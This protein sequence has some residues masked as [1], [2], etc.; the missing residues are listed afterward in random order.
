MFVRRKIKLGL[1]GME[2][3]D[4]NTVC[5]VPICTIVA[6]IEM[7]HPYKSESRPIRKAPLTALNYTVEIDKIDEKICSSHIGSF[8]I[9]RLKSSFK[10]FSVCYVGNVL[11]KSVPLV[12]TSHEG[13]SF[14][15]N[16]SCPGDVEL[17]T[18][19]CSKPVV[20]R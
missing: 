3:I 8:K 7:T 10:S 15:E 18:R 9:I 4:R 16:S 5:I 1:G 19:S 2:A 17:S 11:W 20:L 6:S 13:S 14:P 12:S